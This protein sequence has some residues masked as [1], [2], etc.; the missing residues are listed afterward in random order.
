MSTLFVKIIVLRNTSIYD[1]M[2]KEVIK[3]N[4]RICAVRKKLGLTQKDFGAALGVSRDVVANLEAGRVPVKDPFLKLLCSTYNV[5]EDWLRNGT[6]GPDAMFNAPALDDLVEQLAQQYNL[7]YI[8]REVIRTYV[9]MDTAARVSISRF[10]MQLTRNVERSEAEMLAQQATTEN[11]PNAAKVATGS[12][13]AGNFEKNTAVKHQ[14][15]VFLLQFVPVCAILY[16][17]IQGECG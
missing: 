4:N 3:T 8:G 15:A 11:D 6:G 13:G 5:N 2:W 12:S 10:V 14:T 9:N 7:D 17:R 16:A 1:I